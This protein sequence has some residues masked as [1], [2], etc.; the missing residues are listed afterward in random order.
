MVW[1]IGHVNRSNGLANIIMQGTVDEGRGRGR[2]R[3]RWLDNIT[4]GTDSRQY[5]TGRL[6]NITPDRQQ[7]Q[8]TGTHRIKLG[9]G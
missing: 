9:G 8:S 6:D 7:K 3:T 1:A 2:P 5:Y 4:Q